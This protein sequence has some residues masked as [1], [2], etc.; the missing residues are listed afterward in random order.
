MAGPADTPR[1]AYHRNRTIVLFFDAASGIPAARLPPTMPTTN[2]SRPA[3][4]IGV[5]D[6]GVG[7]LSVLRAIRAGLPGA[8]LTYFADTA[9]APYG[10]RDDAHALLRAHRV[11]EHLIARGARAIVVA[12]NTATAV[13][14]ESLRARWPGVPFVGV[15]PGLKPALALSRSGRIGVMATPATLRSDRF[16]RLCAAHPRPARLH[17]EPCPGLAAL[18]ESGDLDAPALLA[19]ID[20]HAAALRRA[21]VDVVVLGCTHYVFVREPLQRALGPKV[22]IVDTAD[23]VARQVSRVVGSGAASAATPGA[24]RLEATTD[25]RGLQRIA[26]RWLG[27]VAPVELEA[28]V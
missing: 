23:A 24:L 12:C 4:Q 22:T 13:A 20:A 25:T 27:L 1:A 21:E 28:Q 16:A 11:S 10:D 2:D 3:P 9:H 18:I 15:E 19:A 14:I 26:E 17:L 6:S 5:F 7:G 8:R